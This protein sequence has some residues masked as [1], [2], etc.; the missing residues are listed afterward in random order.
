MYVTYEIH[1]NDE[2]MQTFSRCPVTTRLLSHP[3]EESEPSKCSKSIAKTSPAQGRS[4]FKAIKSECFCGAGA[5]EDQRSVR[6]L[7]L[8]HRLNIP[9][10]HEKLDF[11]TIP[12]NYSTNLNMKKLQTARRPEAIYFFSKLNWKWRSCTT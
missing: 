6:N 9:K 3:R 2:V 4:N 1:I 11:T 5:P 7:G 12:F 8:G 10:C